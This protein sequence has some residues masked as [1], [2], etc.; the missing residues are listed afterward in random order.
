MKSYVNYHKHTSYSN[1]YIKDSPMLPKDYWDRLKE[2]YG[3]KPCAFTTVEH[4]WQ[5]TY[6]RIYDELE[7]YNKKNRTNIKFIFGVEAGFVLD[8]F[9]KD[10]A[11][12]IILLAR[13]DNGRKAINKI[14]SEANKTGYYYNPR[15]DMELIM[16][17]PPDDV[18]ITS[19][20]IALWSKY[21]WDIVDDIMIKLHNKFPH[22]YL[23]VQCHHTNSQKELNQHL[24]ELS[25][26]YGMKL[27]AGVDSHVVY[28]EQLKIRDDLL[29]SSN[30]IYEDEQGWFLDYPDYDTLFNRFQKQGILSDEEIQT[31]LDNTNL[32]M[33]FEDII[34]DRNLKVPVVKKYQNNTQEERNEIFKNIL[35][36]EWKAQINDINKNKFNEYIEEIKHDIEEIVS[37]GMADYFIFS[38]EVM[39]LGQEKYG[40]IL[41]P[42]GRGSAV[43]MY[44]NKLLRLTKVDRINSPVLMY[45]ERFLTKERVLESHTPPD[46]DNNVSDREPFIQAQRDLIGDLGTYD[47]IAL[48]TLH[49]KSAFKMYARA[50]NLDP[51][52]ANDVTKQIDKY[53]LAV[54]HAED[55]EKDNMDIF[56][57]VDKTK[58][59]DLIK[60][61][62]IYRG[63][64]DNRKG[65]PCATVAYNGDVE[66]DIGI[67]LCKSETTKKEILTAVIESGTI[68]AFGFLKED[69]LIVDS[70]G[71]TYDIYK[72][73]GIEPFTVNELISKIE[74]DD[75]V[76]NIY[77]DGYTMCVNQC[78]QTKST[79]KVMRYK[80]KN[81]YELTQFIAGIRPSFQSMYKTFENREHFDYGVKALD[82]LLQDEYC[83][84]SF[85]IYQENLMKVLGFAGFP[86]G[87]TY[88][89]IKA[90]S[91]K[92]DYVI[93]EA[94]PKFIKNFAQ[95]IINT[96]DAKDEQSANELADKVWKIIEDSSSYGFN[97]VSGDTKMRR[98]ST[99]GKYNP[100]IEE[101]YLIKN[102]R[103]YAKRTNH[104]NLHDKYNR[105][106]YGCGLSMDEDGIIKKNKIIDIYQ[107]PKAMTY[108]IIT[109]SGK[110]IQCT[111]NH[112]FPTKNGIKLV[113]D[114]NIGESL[115]CVGKYQH[116]YF[117]SSL[118]NGDFIPNTPIKGEQG[119]QT[120]KNGASVVYDNFRKHY[121]EN[122]CVC[123]MCGEKYSIGKRFEVHHKDLDRKHN[124]NDNFQ[125]L[126]AS[127]HKKVHY[128][129]GRTK[130]Y[131]NGLPTYFE[132]IVSI[133]PN[134]EEIVYDV[135]M[136][137]EVAHNFALDNGIVTCNCSHAF[138]MAVDSVTIA[139]LK[140]Y[141]PLEFY[142]SV[143]QRY[144]DKGEKDK[145][146]L[147]KQEMASRGY[148]LLPIK[149]R[150]DN[151]K[152]SINKEQNAISQTMA[153]IKNMSKSAPKILY[154][155]R[156][157]QFVHPIDLLIYLLEE[158]K[159]NKTDVEILI[160]LDYFSEFGKINYLLEMYNMFSD[161]YKKTYVEK[162]KVTRIQEIK[163]AIFDAPTTIYD[164]ISYQ[165]QLLGYTDIIDPTFDEFIYAVESTETNQWGT[166]FASLYCISDGKREQF[167]VDKKYYKDFP[168]EI[169]NVLKCAFR[170]KEKKRKINDEWI[171]T[172]ENEI[173]LSVY[174][175]IY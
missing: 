127:C 78:E 158:T 87:D 32:I 126:C 69:Y 153:S 22:F 64:I 42:T 174:S 82:N 163:D 173:I 44:I 157:K 136:S 39:K 85:I 95:A 161:R 73:I 156:N 147:I 17:L 120:N 88:T 26:K 162:T 122:S 74:N 24:L 58:Y 68:D 34:L 55:D 172:G 2:L 139:Y 70:I 76:W 151:R 143:L 11:G 54:K 91:K 28:E 112:K 114:L 142:K 57:Y 75:K 60:G 128:Q 81:I 43:S 102:D 19:A 108:T 144:T 171:A 14:L 168:F 97:C 7:K 40:G 46:I 110:Q 50:Y 16:Q 31:A 53:E 79:Q 36:K 124:S 113:K 59:G 103:E 96:G 116:Q 121:S 155:M 130:Q 71:L 25:N 101:M 41:T 18:F 106:G 65:H 56:D 135:S 35:R 33:D 52:I 92:K 15:I 38:Y 167:K 51:Q 170:S 23:E 132:E 48:G 72:E 104:L 8:R 115:Y 83:N 138:C 160:K 94:K 165:I 105:Y 119:F 137:E 45:P 20:C 100:T 99:N 62:Q 131:E 37:C 166:V 84:S 86:M 61:C 30:I 90:I 9:S 3:D 107:Q 125:W 150:D 5:S 169:G 141:Y 148:K 111:E 149:F 175:K 1:V 159:L 146:S 164:K 133:I 67:I 117:D 77:S 63:I 109:S 145:V 89:I 154:S 93:K 80:P 98:P 29:K 129:N 49:Y 47:L 118:T 13:N 27:I 66:S 123:E 21:D 140:A 4:Y 152:F 12:H 10:R 6:F 134:K